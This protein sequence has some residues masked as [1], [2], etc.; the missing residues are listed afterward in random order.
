MP[1]RKESAPGNEIAAPTVAELPPDVDQAA[2]ARPEQADTNQPVD[3]PAESEPERTYHD[4]VSGQP[5]NAQGYLVSDPDNEA[6]RVERHRIVADDW[7]S[8]PQR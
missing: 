7:P 8:R 6:E 3:A 4:S 2:S 1:V 5:V